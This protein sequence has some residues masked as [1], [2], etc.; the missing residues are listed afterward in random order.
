MRDTYFDPNGWK[1]CTLRHEIENGHGLWLLCGMC[2][3]SRYFDIA[4]WAREHGVDLHTPFSTLGRRVR[5]RR[6]GTLGVSAYGQPYS[7]LPRE[8]RH[9]GNGPVCPA[10]GSDD[11][12]TRRVL[13]TDYPP[14]FKRRFMLGRAM[15]VCGC[16]T[17][18]NW[19]TQPEGMRITDA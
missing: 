7:N 5:C 10:C 16:E 19:W 2:Q 9:G 4:D 15:Q 6:C 13:T 14:G 3:K 17:C 8:P 12:R 18:D 1:R 11:V